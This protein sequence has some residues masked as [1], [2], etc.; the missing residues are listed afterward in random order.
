M[1]LRV[2][3]RDINGNFVVDI[4]NI[5]V[6]VEAPPGES[7]A[8]IDPHIGAVISSDPDS[9]ILRWIL[10]DARW[11]EHIWSVRASRGIPKLNARLPLIV[12]NVSSS[13]VYNP[14][15]VEAARPLDSIYRLEFRYAITDTEKTVERKIGGFFL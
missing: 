14:P 6:G 4:L 5:D 13:S 8:A 10:Y 3:N 2:V 7:P 15:L 9:V 1:F 12:K 11:R